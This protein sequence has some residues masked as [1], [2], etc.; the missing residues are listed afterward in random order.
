MFGEVVFEEVVFGNV[1]GQMKEG[2]EVNS[3]WCC[4]CH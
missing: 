2:G 4:Q 1:V 3:P